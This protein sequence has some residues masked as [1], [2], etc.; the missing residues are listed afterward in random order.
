MLPAN[1]ISL[2]MTGASGA[3]YGLRL[4][5]CLLEADR[6]VYLMISVP[7][8][9]VVG[10]E[11]DLSIPGRS[12]EIQRMLTQRFGAHDGQLHV[13]GLRLRLHHLIQRLRLHQSQR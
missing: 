1:A 7:G 10:M 6:S 3:Q 11:T 2:A 9:V 4:L 12:K 13:F 8:Q 5:Q